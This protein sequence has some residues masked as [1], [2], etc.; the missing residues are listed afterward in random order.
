MSAA[1]LT[2]VSDVFCGL[3]AA[4]KWAAAAGATLWLV[5]GHDY[6]GYVKLN[7]HYT[8]VVLQQHS[9]GLTCAYNA[10]SGWLVHVV[11]V[12]VRFRGPSGRVHECSRASVA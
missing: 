1:V 11:S 4:A 5:L 12:F 6:N 8:Q 9:D 2:F 7:Y 3:D 10:H